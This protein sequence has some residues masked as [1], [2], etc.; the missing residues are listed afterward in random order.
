V[1]YA[2]AQ[3]LKSKDKPAMPGRWFF[4]VMWNY[5]ANEGFPIFP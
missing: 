5:K 4:I 3:G 2:Q 1:A